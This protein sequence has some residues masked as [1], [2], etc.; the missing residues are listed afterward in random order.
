[1]PIDSQQSPSSID[2]AE[3]E[4]VEKVAEDEAFALDK[5]ISLLEGMKSLMAGI[6]E[7]NEVYTAL[8]EKQKLAIESAKALSDAQRS[9][10]RE[11]QGIQATQKVI[12]VDQQATAEEQAHILENQKATLSG[13]SELR[14]KQA[15][16]A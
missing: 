14:E 13:Q 12:S 4:A 8:E 10:A 6:G 11:I 2:P 3:A 7:L 9:L 16:L 5:L 1:M 15:E